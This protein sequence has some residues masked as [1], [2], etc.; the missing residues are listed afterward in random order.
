M[1]LAVRADHSPPRTACPGRDTTTPDLTQQCPNGAAMPCE[2]VAV[3]HVLRRHGF[4][5]THAART[6]SDTTTFQVVRL[7]LSTRRPKIE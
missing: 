3:L 4:A 1:L 5:V 7:G 6:T 2:P